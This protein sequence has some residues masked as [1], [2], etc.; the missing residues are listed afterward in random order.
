MSRP[1]PKTI[2]F[3]HRSPTYVIRSHQTPFPFTSNLSIAYITKF[4]DKL[5]RIAIGAGEKLREIEEDSKIGPYSNIQ[6]SFSGLERSEGGQRG[7]EGFFSA[8]AAGKAS[9]GAGRVKREAT[10]EAQ[11]LK[12]KGKRRK[13]NGDDDQD[14]FPAPANNDADEITLA[15]TPP[16]PSRSPTPTPPDLP[17]YT[18]PSCRRLLSLPSSAI[19]SL[20]PSFDLSAAALLL[21][22]EKDEHADWH[23]AREMVEKDRK[24]TWAGSV[25]GGGESKGKSEKGAKAKGGEKAD[26]KKQKGQ[27][28]L[29]SFFG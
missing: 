4:G 23:F 15:S 20:R 11:E 25:K 22:K 6:L 26:G 19:D 28:S 2:T 3:T 10:A 8:A 5:L 7:I 17:T 13:V 1:Q 14:G 27:Q 24:K 29:R 21:Q 9:E 12:G 18:C 16:P